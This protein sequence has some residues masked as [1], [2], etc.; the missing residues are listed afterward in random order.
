MARRVLEAKEFVWPVAING[1][2]CM[3]SEDRVHTFA[4]FPE[5]RWP[6][7]DVPL[8]YCQRCLVQIDIDGE[9]IACPTIHGLQ[10]RL[11]A[12]EELRARGGTQNG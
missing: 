7:E 3:A 12:A 9:I 2:T 4:L 5:A 10:A 6:D 11:D 8:L 1:L